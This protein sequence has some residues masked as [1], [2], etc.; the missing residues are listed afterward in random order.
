MRRYLV[1]AAVVTL[2]ASL[3]PQTVGGQLMST[4]VPNS[5]E[6]QGEIGCS[7]VERKLLPTSLREP[8]FWHIDR[9]ASPLL[10]RNE[11]STASVA[12]EAA[13]TFWLSTIESDTSNHHGGVHVAV[14]GPLQLPRVPQYAVQTQSSL[15]RPGMYSLVH[16]H[17]GVEAV[18]VIS[19]VACF[20]TPARAF[21]LRPGETLAVPGETPMRAVVTGVAPR[22]LLAVIIYDAAQPPTTRMEEGDKP[23]LAA[24]K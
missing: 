8:L 3:G 14:V 4:C 22:H 15:F 6:R 12:F 21:T 9:F 10:R 7:I 20:E 5:P 1:I 19:G 11:D 23:Q 18:Y 17:S 24:C 2:V 13:G 16:H